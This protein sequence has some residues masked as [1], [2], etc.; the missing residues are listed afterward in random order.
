MEKVFTKVAMLLPLSVRMPRRDAEKIVEAARIEG[1][2]RSEFLRRS[3]IERAKRV[4]R[5]SEKDL[6]N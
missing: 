4:L 3:G 2:S 1:L 6:T 5:K